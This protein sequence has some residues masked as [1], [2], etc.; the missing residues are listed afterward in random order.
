MPPQKT[1]AD[2]P[3]I[4]VRDIIIMHVLLVLFVAVVAL[5]SY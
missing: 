5:V 2:V 3:V 4:G 1:R